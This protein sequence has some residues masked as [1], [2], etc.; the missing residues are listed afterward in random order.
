MSQQ[1][2]ATVVPVINDVYVVKV[3]NVCRDE[4]RGAFWWPGTRRAP[5]LD[6]WSADL[7]SAGSLLLRICYNIIKGSQTWVCLNET[8]STMGVWKPFPRASF[9]TR[10]SF[11][12][13]ETNVR[14]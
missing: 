2:I 9:I 13:S 14:N 10:L 7:A 12:V 8:R 1:V 3:G 6:I 4:V 11:I 5:C